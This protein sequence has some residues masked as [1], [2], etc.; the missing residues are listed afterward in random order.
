MVYGRTPFAALAMVP[1]M[2]AITNPAHAISLP[3]T[4]NPALADVILR[5][6]EPQSPHSHH[7]A[8][9]PGSCM[10][11]ALKLGSEVCKKY[12]PDPPHTN[13]AFLGGSKALAASQ[14]SMS[15]MTPYI[16]AVYYQNRDCCKGK[17]QRS[18]VG[19]L[20]AVPM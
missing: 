6:L 4:G 17:Q 18:V 5:C 3:D 13:G 1:K 10:R 11:R 7:H 14:Y 12:D 20:K 8:G 9:A 19:F 2:H 16:A 15:S